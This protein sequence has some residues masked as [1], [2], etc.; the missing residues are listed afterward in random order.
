MPVTAAVLKRW[1]AA[2]PS[3]QS[4]RVHRRPAYD[5]CLSSHGSEVPTNHGKGDPSRQQHECASRR[6]HVTRQQAKS[7]HRSTEHGYGSSGR[8]GPKLSRGASAGRWLDELTPEEDLHAV[9]DGQQSGKSAE[10][11][12]GEDEG[13]GYGVKLHIQSSHPALG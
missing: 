13:E 6:P 3:A 1:M 10:D 11:A 4:L 8:L 12:E 9:H 5:S 7:R 2:Y